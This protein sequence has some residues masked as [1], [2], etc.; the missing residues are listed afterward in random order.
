M[1]DN[2]KRKQLSENNIFF[3]INKEW[4]WSI[5]KIKCNLHTALMYLCCLSDGFI[6]SPWDE[7]VE[8]K[9]NNN[10][11]IAFSLST[12]RRAT[13]EYQP[14]ILHMLNC[15]FVVIVFDILFPCQ[16]TSLLYT[17]PRQQGF[18]EVVSLPGYILIC[19]IPSYKNW[20]TQIQ[21]QVIWKHRWVHLVHFW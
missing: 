17:N 5:F 20:W 7:K 6:C 14:G 18:E 4:M 12:S 13:H 2:V 11:I 16:L 21:T 10:N 9:F 1:F 15:E 3:F 8:I 19:H